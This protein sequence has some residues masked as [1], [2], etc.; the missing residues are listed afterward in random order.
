MQN[1]RQI[2]H[3][4]KDVKL[5]HSDF[6]TSNQNF[7][8]KPSIFYEKILNGD[9]D[10]DGQAAQFF[11]NADI[12]SSSYKNL[13]STL[14]NKLINTLFFLNAKKYNEREAA[15][16]YCSKYIIA[17]KILIVLNVRNAGVDLCHK[18]LRKAL[19]FEFT[20]YI[21]DA[22]YYLR[23]HYALVHGNTK[24]FEHYNKLLR[25]ALKTREAENLASEFY[26]QILI[27]YTKSSAIKSETHQQATNAFEQLD[28][29]LDIYPSS[30]LHY[31]SY[32]IESL[33]WLSINNYLETIEVCKKAILFFENKPFE[34][35][36]AKKAF[37]HQQIVCYTQLKMYKEGQ[38]AIE[39]SNSILQQGSYN[40]Y[41][42]LDLCL[43]LALHSKEYQEAYYIFNKAA[44]H[45][46][47][48]Q[49]NPR[50]KE[51]W[52]ILESY[53][54]FLV[55]INK[56]VPIRED[57]R[58]SKFRMGKFLNSV[59]TFS[60]DKRGLNIPILII[61]IVFMIVRKDYD[62]AV[63]RIEAIEKYCSRYLKKGDNF[64][65]NCFIKMLL[66]IPISGFH[67][68]GTER[69]AK[70]YFDQL[71]EVSLEIANQAN[72]VEIIPYEDMWEIVIES[73]EAKFVKF[74][75]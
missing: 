61:Q 1:I 6:V 11:Y 54:H 46:R 63:N 41:I 30:Y 27:P 17:A 51:K 50:I 15:Y 69:R 9:F 40:W 19:H 42:N 14:R 35:K 13:K 67:K 48:K 33:M 2:I 4:V 12:N 55:Y 29:L 71:K 45:K 5:K 73:L 68:A 56:I 62:K 58:F 18:V 72:E 26:L 24:K 43:M 3:L 60:K 28:P 74:K 47:F 65:S 44:N 70:K 25:D 16:L 22:S 39:K 66:Q 8:T 31:I 57:K 49:L 53:I 64:R 21:I 38:V 37:L 32:Y 34:Y 23:S 52:M 59:P 7:D 75:T 10:S 20:D 36:S